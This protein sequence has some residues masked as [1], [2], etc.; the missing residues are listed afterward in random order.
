M[1]TSIPTPLLCA[2]ELGAAVVLDC[3][4]GDPRRLPH[5]VRWIGAMATA[6]ERW[7]R[8]R[9][10][11]ARAAGTVTWLLVVAVSA[12]AAWVVPAG[13]ALLWEPLGSVF[14]ILLVYVTIATHDLIK[15]SRAVFR[16]LEDGDLAGARSAAGMMVSRDTST[17]S[18]ADVVRAA[19]ES[20]A[21]NVSDA[22]IAPLFYAALGGPILAVVYRAVNTLDAMFG[23]KNDRYIDFGRFSAKADDAANYVPARLSGVLLCAAS[24]SAGL[25]V[26]AAWRVMI[27]DAKKHESPNAGYPEAAAAGALGLRF[28][29][30]DTYFGRT[31]SKPVIGE[32]VRPFATNR[33]LEANRLV[34]VSVSVAAV[35]CC[36]LR[37]L[38]AGLLWK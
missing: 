34:V 21:E 18:E 30:V 9:F 8:N 16:K 12:A 35:L 15:H 4:V 5:P 13:A 33:I 24:A 37:F 11:H 29:G 32:A 31:V 27:R 19:V 38:I 22:T 26:R 36:V 14:R 17:S 2:L 20:V 25:S 1:L 28:G 6:V 7:T 3:I 23:Y 10:A